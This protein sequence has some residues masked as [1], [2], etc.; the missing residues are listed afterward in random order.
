[1]RSPICLTALASSWHRN[2]VY[3]SVET[4]DATVGES[5]SSCAGEIIR[6]VMIDQ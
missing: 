3:C 2:L 1:M 6:Q 5:V 4:L